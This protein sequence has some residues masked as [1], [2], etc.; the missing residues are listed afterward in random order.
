[1]AASNETQPLLSG[2]ALFPSGW[3]VGLEPET[4]SFLNKQGLRIASY[5]YR[6]KEPKIRGSVL[7]IHGYGCHWHWE[8]AACPRNVYENSWIEHLNKAGYNVYGFDN[9]SHGNSEGLYG[10]RCYVER[11]Q[12]FVEDALQMYY[13]MYEEEKGTNL[14]VLGVSMGGCVA[15]IAAEELDNSQSRLTGL[16]L[17]APMLSLERVK[18]KPINRILLPLS[19]CISS[20]WPTLAVGSKAENEFFPEIKA[21]NDSDEL[22]YHGKVRARVVTEFFS[23]VDRAVE[24]A[25]RIECPRLL[26]HSKIDTMTDPEGSQL[27]YDQSKDDGKKRLVWC[28]EYGHWHGLTKEPGNLRL[29]KIVSDWMD[30]L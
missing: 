10:V 1:M 12:D 18:K 8:F 3:G 13:K 26:L 21:E 5:L 22:N 28:E 6:S 24:S 29:A 7:C 25:P 2:N 19:G 15:A 16:V 11:F 4:G 27:F 20:C 17:V 30:R 14:F 9:Q 23:A